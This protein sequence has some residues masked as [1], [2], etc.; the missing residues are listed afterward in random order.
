M[1]WKKE[2]EAYYRELLALRGAELLGQ[3]GNQQKALIKMPCGH[4]KL[5]NVSSI[6]DS[7]LFR[8]KFRCYECRLGEAYSNL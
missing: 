1:T 5:M 8:A 4:E 3:F 2:T 6:T 7:K